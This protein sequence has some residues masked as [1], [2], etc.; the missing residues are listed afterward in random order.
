MVQGYGARRRNVYGADEAKLL[1]YSV[2]PDI[3]STAR[4]VTGTV[5]LHAIINRSGR[6]E[7][8]QYVSGPSELAQAAIEAAEWQQYRVYRDVEL[9]TTIDIVFP[10]T[11]N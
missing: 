7:Q 6:P 11:S 2:R 1:V 9:D 4:G 3:P 8:L 5:V 10:P